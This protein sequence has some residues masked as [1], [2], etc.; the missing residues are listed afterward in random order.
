[1]RI[2]EV[3]DAVSVRAFLNLPRFIYKDDPNWV[4]P[5]ENDIEAVF[6]PAKNHFH[7][8]GQCIRWILQD[9]QRGVI[10]R[11][12]A[13]INERKARKQHPYAGGCGFF[14]C[15]NDQAAADL[16]FNTARQW[17]QDRG[18]EAMDGPIN[19]GENDVWWGLLIDGFSR[20]YYGMNYNRPYYQNL[21]EHYGFRVQYE[22]ISNKINIKSPFPAR[23]E[24]I[25]KW[26]ANRPGHRFDHLHIS[27]FDQQAQEFLEIYNDGWKD[28]D[29]FSP[30]KYET[31]REAFDK[32]KPIVDEKLI[33][34]AYV[35]DEPASFVMILPDTNEL[36]DGLNGKLNLWGKLKFVW[37]K[38]TIR[39]R[40]MRAVIMG[41]KE[42]FRNMG[43][44][45]ALFIKLRDY[46]ASLGHYE[47]LELSWVGDFN[48]KMLALHEATGAQYAKKHVTYR[49]SFPPA[50]GQP[51]SGGK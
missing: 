4:C 17:L 31:V 30:M 23:F 35:N 45:S 50:S 32:M 37:R 6:N 33:W 28:F 47:E 39:H 16:L 19:F 42:K 29:Q 22:Q 20:P 26:V 49:Y 51:S 5:L 25:A 9:Q 2:I 14:E 13:F 48:K 7:Q 44:E 3:N 27:R 41:T 15:V 24:K 21:F 12:A 10:G 18:M 8:H 34:Y 1:M 40:R 11:I 46:V 38:R 43:L 36:I